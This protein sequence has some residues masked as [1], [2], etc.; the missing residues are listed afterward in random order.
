MHQQLLSRIHTDGR[1]V[2]ALI[3]ISSA[4]SK[5]PDSSTKMWQFPLQFNHRHRRI[6]VTNAINPRAAARNN[7]IHQP[8][9]LDQFLHRLPRARSRS[10]IAPSG[11]PGTAAR[12]SP[13]ADC[14]APLLCRAQH[15]RVAGFQRKHRRI[16]RDIRPR[17]V[18]DSHHSQRHAHLA[19]VQPVRACPLARVSPIGS[20]SAA[21]RAPPAP[22][23]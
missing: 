21:P 1:C 3:T 10:S 14:C 22:S 13:A 16:N 18:N 5:S 20:P 17:L 15:N 7:H 8:A 6:S 11:T 23:P 2:F 4:M 19:D 9:R 12:I